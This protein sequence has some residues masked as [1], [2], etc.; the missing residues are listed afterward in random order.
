MKKYFLFILLWQGVL[1]AADSQISL[2]EL[3]SSY[4]FAIGTKNRPLAIDSL[5][6]LRLLGYADW[7][8]F[9]GDQKD[10]WQQIS[11]RYRDRIRSLGVN[12]LRECIAHAKQ[13][14]LPWVIDKIER[15]QCHIDWS[16]F[17]M[18]E[19]DPKVSKEELKL[20]RLAELRSFGKLRQLDIENLVSKPEELK[21]ITIGTIKH[22]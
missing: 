21:K 20:H 16:I 2:R 22:H 11:D 18:E 9:N 10:E 19:L 12:N 5:A 1:F 6:A 8:Y 14:V 13:E 15:D 7:Q 17:S 3:K 4:I